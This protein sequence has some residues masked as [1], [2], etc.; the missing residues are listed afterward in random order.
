MTL[1]VFNNVSLDGYFT[2]A[3]GDMSWA[4]RSDPQ[5]LKFTAGNAKGTTGV[6]VFGRV[7]YQQMAGFWPTPMARES[8]PAVAKA[9]NDTPKLV[10]SRTLK[11]AA[12]SNT[13]LL[14][15]NLVEELRARKRR[16]RQDLLIMGSGTLVAQLTAA[17]LIDTY[18]LVVV[19]IVLGAGRT[20]FEGVDPPRALRL[21]GSRAFKN[22]N[23]VLTYEAR[24]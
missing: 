18:T 5:W 4:H 9:M 24:R 13:T 7:T 17:G 8:M 15:G 12:W 11:K 14:K 1:S 6:F 22:G 23:V 19:P 16:S 3:H 10:F 20:L 2:D 21:A